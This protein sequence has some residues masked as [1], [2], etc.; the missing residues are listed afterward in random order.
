MIKKVN[1]KLFDK[2]LKDLL[3][4]R[5]QDFKSFKKLYGV[6]FIKY[7]KRGNQLKAIEHLMLHP[8][9]LYLEQIEIPSIEGVLGLLPN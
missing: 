8:T 5:Y 3:I 1:K 2:Y 7:E 4:E 6:T 9:T